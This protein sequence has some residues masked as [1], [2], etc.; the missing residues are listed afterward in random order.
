LIPIG[1]G[2]FGNT[3]QN[4]YICLNGNNGVYF[5]GGSGNSVVGCT[6]EANQEWGILDQ[7]SDNDYAYNTI[8][9]NL[10][11]SIGY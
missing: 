8:Y 10:D 9:N 5:A 7:R 3:L 2:S 1:G 11:G 6:I 4:D